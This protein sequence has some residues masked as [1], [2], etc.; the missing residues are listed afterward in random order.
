VVAVGDGHA[1]GVLFDL[2]IGRRL[3]ISRWRHRRGRVAFAELGC[4]SVIASRAPDPAYAPPGG[5][6]VTLGGKTT[7]VKTYGELVTAIVHPSHRI[8]PRYPADQVATEGESLMALAYLNDVMTVAA[9]R[10]RRVL[11]VDLRGRT[12]TRPAS[13]LDG[14]PLM[15]DERDRV[16]PFR[17]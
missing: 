8:T 10:P 11:A 1:Q 13:L 12:A 5:A 3:Q 9:H 2:E 17:P 16:Q 6:N 14:D 7:W 4:N 15:P